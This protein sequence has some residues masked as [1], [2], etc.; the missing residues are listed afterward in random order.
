[1]YG[2]YKVGFIS[3]KLFDNKFVNFKFR[4]STKL[5]LTNFL[6][7]KQVI[8]IFVSYEVFEKTYVFVKI[9]SLAKFLF[10]PA[11]KKLKCSQKEK[12]L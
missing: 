8:Q 9:L 2:T 6:E 7:V 3:A 10:F 4:F 12:Y 11:I 5:S 1:M